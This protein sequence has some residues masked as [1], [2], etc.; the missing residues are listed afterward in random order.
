MKP[1]LFLFTFVLWQGEKIL[2]I[3]FSFSFLNQKEEICSLVLFKIKNTLEPTL[4]VSAPFCS[5]SHIQKIQA[6]Y[7]LYRQEYT[8]TR[9]LVSLFVHSVTSLIRVWP[10]RDSPISTGFWGKVIWVRN[11]LWQVQHFIKGEDSQAIKDVSVGLI[12]PLPWSPHS[13]I[14]S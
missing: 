2:Q 11:L 6:L 7:V 1:F 13:N 3:Q 9:T 4:S 8:H 10:L 5:P 12:K 14:P